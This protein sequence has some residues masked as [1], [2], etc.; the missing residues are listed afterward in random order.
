MKEITKTVFE[1][2]YLVFRNSTIHGLG[3]FARMALPSGCRVIEY[4]GEKID[5]EESLRRCEANN[6]FIFTLSDREDID[7][8]VEW[9]PARLINHSC[10]A[11]CEAELIDDRIW[12]VARRAIDTG[13][14]VTFNYGYD[15]TEYKDYPCR[16][17]GP[18]CV[19][20]IVAEEFFDH[21]RNMAALRSETPSEPELPDLAPPSLSQA[22]SHPGR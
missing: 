6:P 14:E 8:A 7:G 12:I 20:Y 17:G 21:V 3:A 5:K 2:E 11:N 13:E 9:N 16:C 19:G 18:S 15:L 22:S 10:E 4:I 1:T